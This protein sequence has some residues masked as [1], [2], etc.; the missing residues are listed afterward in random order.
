MTSR[1]EEKAY[2]GR[3]YYQ[4]VHKNNRILL[5]CKWYSCDY[6]ASNRKWFV[7]NMKS[8]VNKAEEI[9][10]RWH[11]RL[12]HVRKKTLCNM[13]NFGLKTSRPPM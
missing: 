8:R 3:S 4:S 2:I 12:G 10:R 7:Q 5:K 13:I 11:E 6:C 9:L 1:L